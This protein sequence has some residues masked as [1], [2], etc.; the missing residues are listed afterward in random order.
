MR[1]VRAYT[2]YATTKSGK[3]VAFTILANN[4]TGESSDIRKK[5][6]KVMLA[7]VYLP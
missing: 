7:L 6:E 4:F 3:K 5:M 2:G 1:R